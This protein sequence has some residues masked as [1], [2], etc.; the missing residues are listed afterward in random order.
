MGRVPVSLVL[1]GQVCRVL[2]S[3][4]QERLAKARQVSR[5]ASRPKAICQGRASHG[6]QVQFGRVTSSPDK[7]WLTI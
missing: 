6:R 5:A 3:G 4:V 1:S 2:A 7:S